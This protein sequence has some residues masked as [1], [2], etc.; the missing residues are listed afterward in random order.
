MKSNE[1]RKTRRIRRKRGIRKRI[2]GTHEHPRLSV[3]RSAKHIYAQIIDDDRGVT[4]A[5]ASSVSKA[6]RGQLSA[7]SNVAAAKTV[8]IALAEQAK[9]KGVEQVRFDRNGYRF[10]GRLKAL[11]DAV[12]EA[13][14]RC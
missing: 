2:H 9:S 5:E 6:L 10:H 12:R 3:F 7:G 1:L 13:G 14:V 4:L 8:G 11:A